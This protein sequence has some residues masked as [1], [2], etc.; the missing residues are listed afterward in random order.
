[1]TDD[2]T[3]KKLPQIRA[4]EYFVVGTPWAMWLTHPADGVE[5]TWLIRASTS[6]GNHYYDHQVKQWVL[7]SKDPLE[8]QR[9]Q[10]PLEQCRKLIDEACER[11]LEFS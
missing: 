6:K 10:L 4:T 7:A 1:M 5:D 2:T 3:M 8:V 9:I 11:F